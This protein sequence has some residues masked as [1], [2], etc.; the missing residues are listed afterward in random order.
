MSGALYHTTSFPNSLTTVRKS[1]LRKPDGVDLGPRYTGA[2]VSRDALIGEESEDDP[3]GSHGEQEELES[4]QYADP[5]EDLDQQ[6]SE[7]DQEIE[8][9]EAFE[10]GDEEKFA[11][12]T[13]RDSGMSKAVADEGRADDPEDGDSEIEDMDET[14]NSESE[15]EG[16]DDESADVD[17]DDDESVG[18]ADSDDTSISDTLTEPKIDDRAALRKMMA[19]EQKTIA[20]SLSK[21]AKADVEKGRA[22]K[23]QRSTFDSLL[24]TRIK[25]QKGLIASNSMDT[26][27]TESID[28]TKAIEA[29]EKAALKLWDTISDLRSSL[30]P[31]TSKN[32]P[33]N[34]YI[35]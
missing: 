7:A 35:P 20:A 22:I 19:D 9:D 8:S 27:G 16:D 14:N 28:H 32:L 30:E 26:F 18:D 3:F 13:F 29:A 2:R 1:K 6:R 25:L 33:S 17:M 15:V 21:A 23:H 5:D 11:K 12:F 24:N 31:S 34:P 10:S 4:A